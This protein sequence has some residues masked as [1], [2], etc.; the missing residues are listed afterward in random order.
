[1]RAWLRY[2]TGCDGDQIEELMMCIDEWVMD[3]KEEFK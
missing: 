1:M 3:L 2:E